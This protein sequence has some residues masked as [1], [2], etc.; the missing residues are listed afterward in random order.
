MTDN[1]PEIASWRAQLQAVEMCRA[2][3]NGDPDAADRMFDY[4]HGNGQLRELV[5]ALSVF[6]VSL[7]RSVAANDP[8]VT[9]EAIW[10]GLAARA[11]TGLHG[12]A[13]I[14]Q[15]TREDDTK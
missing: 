9:E 7:A 12:T 3:S 11:E 13:E 8:T 15:L 14:D 2:V 5:S 10:D 1:N 6:A 4:E